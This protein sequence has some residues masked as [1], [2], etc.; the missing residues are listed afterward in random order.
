MSQEYNDQLME[1]LTQICESEQINPQYI[2]LF[3]D[4]GYIEE[5]PPKFSPEG[6]ET[7]FIQLDEEGNISK[8]SSIKLSNLKFNLGKL[9]LEITLTGLSVNIEDPKKLLVIGFRFLERVKRLASNDL[10]S[11]DASLLLNVQKLGYEE[12]IVTVDNLTEFVKANPTD[13]KLGQAL[14]R[15]ARLDC[16]KLTDDAI[17]INEII[18]IQHEE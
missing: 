6:A 16:I 11:K 3:L 13:G 8:A 10:K 2:Q 1:F 18:V 14:E 7:A 9:L 4:G 17:V 15:L 12:K 5:I